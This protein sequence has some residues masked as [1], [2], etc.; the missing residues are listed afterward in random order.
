M[1]ACQ[2]LLEFWNQTGHGYPCYLFHID[3][4]SNCLFS[5]CQ[6]PSF[7]DMKSHKAMEQDVMLKRNAGVLRYL[8][9]P[10]SPKVKCILLCLQLR[11]GRP[12]ALLLCALPFPWV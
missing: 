2:A 5:N 4:H 12:R 3:L 7:A 10:F 1:F 9:S 8:V 6:K 11:C